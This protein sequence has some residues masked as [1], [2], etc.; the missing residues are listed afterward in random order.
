MPLSE[1]GALLLFATAMAFTPGPNT[2]LSA[3][4]AANR[5]LRPA[6]RF[7][8]AV[9]VGWGL[10]LLACIA[11]LGAM[12]AAAPVLRGAVKL[13][14]LAY[15]GWLAWRLAGS[16]TLASRA[17][18]LDVGFRQGV[19]LQF[20]NVKAWMNGLVISAGWVTVDAQVLA[21]TATVL[22]LMMAYGI[23]SNLAYA[24]LGSSL[25]GWL[26][27][28]RRLQVFNRAL[29]LVLAATAVWMATL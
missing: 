22:P 2:T 29:A 10:M 1:L 14:G 8:F 26:A 19:A 7:V 25:R 17:G 15:M 24:L 13:A 18:G 11:G 9:P 5:G 28:G 20:V 4:I 27:H 3:A 21:R 12:L 16:T 23:A 6:L